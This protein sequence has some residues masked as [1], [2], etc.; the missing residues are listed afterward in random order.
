MKAIFFEQHGGP[1]VLKYAE[2][3]NPKPRAGQ[4]LLKVKAVSL[5]HLDIWVRRGWH[6]LQLEMPHIGGSDIVGEIVE[7][8]GPGSWVTGTKVIVNPG[9][10]TLDDEWTRRGMDSVSPGYKIIG[11]QCRGGF[12]EYVTVPIENLYS[13]PEGLSDEEAASSLLVGVTAWRM[14]FVRAGLRA[15]MSVLVVGAGG[16][17]NSMSILLAKAAGA[18]VIALSSSEEKCER[19]M[20]LGAAQ[21]INYRT[22]T[23]W[24]H[25]VV[26][27]TRG[28]GVDVVVDNV[29]TATFAKSLRSV[30]RGGTI[31][32]VGNTSGH[33]VVFD[34]RLIFTKQVSIVGS[35]MGSRQDFVDM[36]QFITRNRLKPVVDKVAPLSDGIKLLQEM[37]SGEQFGKLVLRP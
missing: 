15:G 24:H 23:S 20:R 34:N 7:V 21:V 30:A 26:K 22:S 25:D 2:L 4:A 9:F 8:N 5:N 19:A 32:T 3:P 29:G 1:E 36:L 31:V 10:N 27:L 16:G 37:E 14:L 17:V 13:F 35:T 33:E 28:R 6:G 18:H 12:A 11:E